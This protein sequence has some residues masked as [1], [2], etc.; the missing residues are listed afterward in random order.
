MPRFAYVQSVVVVDKVYDAVRAE[1]Q[2]R[3]AYFLNE[4]EK[5]KV[6]RRKRNKER[7]RQHNVQLI[8]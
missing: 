6:S 5:V 8:N 3:G 1:F 2:K 7:E 4:E